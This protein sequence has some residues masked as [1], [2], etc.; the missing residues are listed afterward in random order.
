MSNLHVELAQTASGVP[1][2]EFAPG[3]WRLTNHGQEAT[4]NI[5]CN[6]DVNGGSEI[7]SSDSARS[8]SVLISYAQ[9]LDCIATVAVHCPET[10]RL[11]RSRCRDGAGGKR[12][13][14]QGEG[15]CGK[16]FDLFVKYA[17][18]LP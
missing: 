12:S 17:N 18:L 5:R 13:A 3:I 6:S 10:D 7:A 15:H 11:V 1:S 4:C 14:V 16:P 8:H 9:Y 2:K